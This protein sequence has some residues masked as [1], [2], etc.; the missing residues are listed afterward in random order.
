M[1]WA[2]R[3]IDANKRSDSASL[4]ADLIGVPGVSLVPGRETRLVAAEDRDWSMCSKQG[5]EEVV[6]LR[7]LVIQRIGL[8]SS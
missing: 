7:I 2:P 3:Y 8:V 4:D 6:A 1:C 5:L